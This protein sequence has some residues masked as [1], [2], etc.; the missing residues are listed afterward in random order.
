VKEVL[1]RIAP[2]PIGF[3]TEQASVSHYNK[4]R[5]LPLFVAGLLSLP[6]KSHHRCGMA[7]STVYPL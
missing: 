3:N 4:Q 6:S 1:L 2:E 7:S 5:Q